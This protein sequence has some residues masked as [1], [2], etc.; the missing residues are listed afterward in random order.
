M[1]GTVNFCL[2]LQMWPQVLAL[3][4]LSGFLIL[5]LGGIAWVMVSSER[6]QVHL[7]GQPD[8]RASVDD[9]EGYHHL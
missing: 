3:Q 5:S 1:S 8:P 2:W 4:L 6:C 9:E 7:E